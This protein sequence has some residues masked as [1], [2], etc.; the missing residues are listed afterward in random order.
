M[1]ILC[2]L[3][4]A[5]CRQLGS[6]LVQWPASLRVVQRL[7]EVKKLTYAVG[8]LSFLDILQFP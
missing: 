6:L 3:V 5:P 2:H 7:E 4:K 1:L 8:L